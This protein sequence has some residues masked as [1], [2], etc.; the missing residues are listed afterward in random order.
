[1]AIGSTDIARGIT[2]FALWAGVAVAGDLPA[3]DAVFPKVEMPQIEL[4]RLLFYDPILSGGKTVSC[5]TCHHP[6]HATGDGVSLGLGDGAAGLGPERKVD[7]TN[8]PEDRIPR[9]APA[10]F[11]VGAVEY[12]SFFHDGRLEVDETRAGGIRTPLGL[13]MEQGFASLLSAQTMFPVLSGDEMAGHLGESDVSKAVRQGLLTGPGGAWDILAQRVAGIPE[14]R[15]MFD[16]VIGQKPV[17]F[18]DISDAIAAFVAF[19]WRAT[20]SDFDKS[21]RGE[22]ELTRA[23]A[24]GR[25]L[26]YGKAG[27]ANCHSGL[28][29]TDHD[30]HAIAMPQIGPGKRAAFE[31][32]AA[33]EGRMRVTGNP[34][35]AFKF[36]TP[37]LRNVVHTLPYGHAGVYAQLEDVIR[38]H[39]N[40]EKHLVD[41]DPAQAIL[42]D[43]AGTVDTTVMD[44]PT[45]VARIAAANEL[46]PSALTHGQVAAIIAF[47]GALTDTASLDGQLG[48]PATVPSGLP[49]DQ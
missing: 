16:D 5:A 31:S 21:L 43:L 32:G 26:F 9:N 22:A 12:R 14:Y 41:Y 49:V 33:D 7:V 13:E 17:Y 46:T 37:S 2:A 15:A 28:F 18:H 42:P 8:T 23:Q 10:L 20:D 44:D 6:R 45:E 38:H 29:Q 34:A 30:F 24:H 35:D 19:E 3:P 40:P 47:L 1:M 4:G 36:R 11:N 25:D 39:L 27:C 48:V